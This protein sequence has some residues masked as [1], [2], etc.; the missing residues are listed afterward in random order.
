MDTT[1]HERVIKKLRD[2]LDAKHEQLADLRAAWH[3][4]FERA[5]PEDEGPH[6]AL[7]LGI[8]IGVVIGWLMCY[9]ALAY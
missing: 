7:S 8:A 3:R 5:A 6:P 9:T 2:E 1:D 4:R